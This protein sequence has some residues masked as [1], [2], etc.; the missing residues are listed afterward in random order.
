[1]SSVE[2]ADEIIVLDKG[3]VCECGT[4]QELIAKGGL[5]YDIYREQQEENKK[6]VH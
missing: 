5:Y 3:K 1:L 4:H 6:Q 2:D